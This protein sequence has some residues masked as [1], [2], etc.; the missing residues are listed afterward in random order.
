MLHLNPTP[1][2]H[3][4][5]DTGPHG[6]PT[7]FSLEVIQVSALHKNAARITAAENA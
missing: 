3:Q 7:K 1:V 6:S 5:R 2:R 4:R